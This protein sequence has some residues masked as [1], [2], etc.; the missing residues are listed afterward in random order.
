MGIWGSGKS[1]RDPEV[2]RLAADGVCAY[3]E[4]LRP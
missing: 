3:L 1:S 2:T 4:S